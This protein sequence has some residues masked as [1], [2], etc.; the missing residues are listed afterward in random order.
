[1]KNRLRFTSLLLIML[2]LCTPAFSHSDRTDPFGGHRDNKNASG[3]GSYHYPCGGYSAHLHENGQC[4]YK[5]PCKKE[6]ATPILVKKEEP[7]PVPLTKKT[8]ASHSNRLKE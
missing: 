8:A 5:T 1:M 2:I 6:Q 7:N 4:P 3:L